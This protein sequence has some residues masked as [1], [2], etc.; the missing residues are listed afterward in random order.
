M[1]DKVFILDEI[2]TKA[3]MAAAYRDAYLE[4]YAP[5]ARGRGMTLE[6][7]RLTPPL[8]LIEGCNTLHFLWSVENA[9]AFW[10]MRLGGT[11]DRP[12][13]PSGREKAVWWEESK[14]MT[15]SRRR[16]VL[17]DYIAAKGAA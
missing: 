11:G 15:V 1:S 7:V 6:S 5:A 8:E 16:S 12:F 2:V 17:V 4:R 14:D 9:A 3:G 13:D 10:G